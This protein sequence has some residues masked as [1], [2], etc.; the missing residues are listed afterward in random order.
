MTD[1]RDLYR[2]IRSME[3]NHESDTIQLHDRVDIELNENF[4]IETGVVGFTEDG[5]ILHLDEDAAEFL[6]FHGILN[7]SENV[8]EYMKMGADSDASSA[9]SYMMGEDSNDSH[10][11][12]GAIRWRILRQHPELVGKYGPVR[13]MAAIEDVAHEVGDVEEIGSSD[14]SGW[15]KEVVHALESGNYDHLDSDADND[16]L[17]EIK[18]LAHGKN[19][20]ELEE[21]WKTWAL[22]GAAAI[23]AMLGISHMEYENAIKSDPQLAKLNSY[24][25]RAIKSGDEYKIKE[26]K[27]RLQKTYDHY[28]TTGDEIRDETGKPVDP[29]YEAEYQGRKVTLNKPM[30]GDVAKSKVYVKKPNGKVVKV[31]FG[32]PNMRIKKN[33]P[34]HRKSFRAR[35]HC[36]NPGPKWKAR[37][38]SCRAW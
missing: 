16:E 23:A 13:I 17:N 9:G 26:L 32:D 12:E 24:L 1:T 27:D 3:E 37:Y 20:E 19:E 8:D 7:E 25:E 11:A 38:W 18:K 22:G 15:V 31:N 2:L 33:S 5:I 36:E 4:V 35:H 6:G 28:S 29:M 30:A 10:P 34:G 14:V 21:G